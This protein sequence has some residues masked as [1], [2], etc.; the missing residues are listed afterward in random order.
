MAGVEHL[1]AMEPATLRAAGE[2]KLGRAPPPHASEG[3]MRAVLAYH[4][5]EKEGTGLK[6]ATR[7]QLERLAD[8]VNSKAGRLPSP[9]TRIRAGTNLLRE[10]NGVIHEVK[11][12]DDGFEYTG[13]RYK[14]LS[15]IAREITGARWSGP[16]FFGLN[17]GGVTDVG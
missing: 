2:E 3:Y 8:P 17:S 15:A 13:L 1:D 6:P 9:A 5:Q 7:R 16:R 14:S 4:L 12:L 10:W 11:A